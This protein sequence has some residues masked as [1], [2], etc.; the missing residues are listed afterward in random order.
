DVDVEGLL[1]GIYLYK[2]GGEGEVRAQILVAGVT[3]PDGLRAQELLASEWGVQADVWSV[4]SWSELRKEA[5]AKEIANLRNPATDAGTPY[6][7]QALSRAQGPFVAASDWMRSVPDQIRK[8]VPGDY[9]TLGTDG[10][11]FSDTR[12]AARRVFNVDAQSIVVAALEALG[13][14]GKIDQA[15]VAEAAARY[16]I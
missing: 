11:G 6:V 16:R 13:R 2:R 9:T 4:T 5:L 8:W 3:V 15:K 7:T 14:A 12:P 1:K 10:F